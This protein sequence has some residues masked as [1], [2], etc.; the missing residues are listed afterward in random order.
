MNLLLSRFLDTIIDSILTIISS[1]YK[2]SNAI[3]PGEQMFT[4]NDA[5]IVDDLIRLTRAASE[6][7]LAKIITIQ[8]NFA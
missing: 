5:S 8:Q 4:H 2:H 7:A 3:A 1:I 6:F